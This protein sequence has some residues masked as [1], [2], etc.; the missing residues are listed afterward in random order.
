[1]KLLMK[2]WGNKD[3]HLDFEK[4][5]ATPEPLSALP[6]SASDK[7]AW[8]LKY[9][10][11]LES[12]NKR[13]ALSY[14]ALKWKTV[15][16]FHEAANRLEHYRIAYGT[17]CL[18]DW[19]SRNWGT[20]YPPYNSRRFQIAKPS[21]GKPHAWEFDT[22][23]CPPFHVI[24]K[25]SEQL[26]KMPLHLYAYSCAMEAWCSSSFIAGYKVKKRHL[27]VPLRMK[28]WIT[29]SSDAEAE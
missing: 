25:L 14:S 2:N 26:P 21:G 27:P 29:G 6:V 1:M 4:I 7:A 19:R 10:V 9:G 3:G 11:A 28:S 13:E 20:P 18:Q 5:V 12:S 8:K 16:D 15:S 22:F 24:R 17:Y 23:K